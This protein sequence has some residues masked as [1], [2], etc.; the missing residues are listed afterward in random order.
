MVERETREQAQER[1]L[2]LQAELMARLEANPKYQEL[3]WY[4]QEQLTTSLMPQL[5]DPKYEIGK[6]LQA[7]QVSKNLIK[8]LNTI[9]LRIPNTSEDCAEI[10]EMEKQC[11]QEDLEEIKRIQKGNFEWVI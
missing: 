4:W 9:A 3:D 5:F 8:Q 6:R 2:T 7:I 10:I 1:I 11:I